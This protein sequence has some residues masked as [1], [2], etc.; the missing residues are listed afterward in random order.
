MAARATG[1]M[2]YPRYYRFQATTTAA[3][4]FKETEVQTFVDAQAGNIALLT[5]LEIEIPDINGA[6]DDV[7]IQ[8]CAES[9]TA[10][11]NINHNDVIFSKRIRYAQVGTAGNV[12]IQEN[13]LYFQLAIPFPVVRE[14]LYIGMQSTLSGAQSVYGRILYTTKKIS[15][16]NALQL[17][18]S[19]AL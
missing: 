10:M 18:S 12:V 13:P 15:A 8:V 14:K 11:L 2:K 19:A 6:N 17:L 4:T 7:E 9:Q 5:S 1:A 16:A 3:D